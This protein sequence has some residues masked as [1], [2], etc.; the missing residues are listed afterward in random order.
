[1]AQLSNPDTLVKV[2]KTLPPRLLEFFRRFPPTNDYATG[3]Q[4][5]TLPPPSESPSLTPAT[6]ILKAS[7]VWTDP[8]FNPFQ[9]WKNPITGR[10]RG[11]MYGLRRQAD[12][13]NMA[14]RYGVEEL[15][16][17]SAKLGWVKEEKREQHGLRVKGTG[18]RQRVKGKEWERTQKGR[19]EK[20][21][22]A[23]LKMPEMI[24]TWKER[25][26]GRGWKKWPK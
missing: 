14:R 4:R 8:T 12:I 16:P 3:P 9:P 17:H 23:M 21:R 10:W 5:P 25:G 11:A 1:M 15:L 7:I 2:A 20:R 26:H 19:L 24:Q 13:V 6:D 22:E 18:E